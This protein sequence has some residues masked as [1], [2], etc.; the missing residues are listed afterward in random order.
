MLNLEKLFL[1][2]VKMLLIFSNLYCLYTIQ[3]KP[4]NVVRRDFPRAGRRGTEKN[5]GSCF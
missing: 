5:T 1:T 4:R 3:T 2:E